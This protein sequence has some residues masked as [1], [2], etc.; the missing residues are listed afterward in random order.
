MKLLNLYYSCLLF[1]ILCNLLNVYLRYYHLIKYF[2]KEHEVQTNTF[3]EWLNEFDSRVNKCNIVSSNA[4]EETL[5]KLHSF[6]EEHAE[7]QSFFNEIEGNFKSY[8]NKSTTQQPITQ[9]K[10]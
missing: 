3:F 5:K 7:K 2:R 10:V 8:N 4:I 9:F 6:I 1:F